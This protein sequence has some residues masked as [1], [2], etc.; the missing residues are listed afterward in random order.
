MQIEVYLIHLICFSKF[1]ILLSLLLIFIE[2]QPHR[3]NEMK[4]E[5]NWHYYGASRS[6]NIIIGNKTH[7]TT[8]LIIIIN[9]N[10]IVMIEQQNKLLTE[11][12]MIC[13]K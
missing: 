1:C 10:I 8:N 13:E 5:L 6:T 2:H 11:L 9:V 7:C 3:S 12:I 4:P